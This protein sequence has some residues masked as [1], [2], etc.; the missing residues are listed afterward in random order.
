[1]DGRN[2]CVFA[3]GQT[4]TCK[5]FTMHGTNEEPRIISRALEELFR[6]ASLDNSS[7]FTFTM[8]MLEVYM[9]NLKD[10]LSPRQSGRPHEQYMTK[11]NL[12]IET[13]PKG[14]IEIEGLLEV[15]ISDYAKAKWCLK[16]LNIF[17]RGDALEAKSEV[18]KLWM[19][20]LGG[21]K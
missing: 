10:L 14:L 12:N 13:D 2:V 17:W 8:S 20:D 4:G 18:R 1:M 21:S 6:Q 15:Q 5:T 9:G 7:S 11:C 3:Y 16:R 19:I